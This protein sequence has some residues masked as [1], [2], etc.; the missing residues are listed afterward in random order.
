MIG[1]DM[2]AHL[3]KDEKI[4]FAYTTNQI[5]INGHKRLHE[6]KICKKYLADS[7]LKKS[8]MPKH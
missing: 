1:G 5:E 3:G 7:S 4:N 6:W 8:F 2:N